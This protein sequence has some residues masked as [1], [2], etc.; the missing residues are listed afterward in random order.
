MKKLVL[1]LSVLGSM[2]VVKAAT[3]QT[4]NSTCHTYYIIDKTNTCRMDNCD[5]N[6][7]IQV[8]D[9]RD[10]RKNTFLGTP[11]SC[12]SCQES[13]DKTSVCLKKN[14]DSLEALISSY[15][16][17]Y[18]GYFGLASNVFGQPPRFPPQNAIFWIRNA[19]F[20]LNMVRALM[21]AYKPD[22]MVQQYS[23]P[24]DLFAVLSELRYNDPGTLI[25]YFL[26][27]LSKDQ[28]DAMRS[29]ALKNESV[30]GGL[31][32]TSY[33]HLFRST[34]ASEFQPNREVL[35]LLKNGMLSKSEVGNSNLR[36]GSLYMKYAYQS[37]NQERQSINQLIQLN[38]SFQAMINRDEFGANLQDAVANAELD[39]ETMRTVQSLLAAK[40]A[41]N[42]QIA[43]ALDGLIGTKTKQIQSK[44][45]EIE[46]NLNSAIA[47]SD[48]RS[49]MNILRG[50]A[51]IRNLDGGLLN[52]TI[53]EGY[54]FLNLKDGPELESIYGDIML[55]L[56]ASMREVKKIVDSLEKLQDGGAFGDFSNEVLAALSDKSVVAKSDAVMEMVIE[57]NSK[58]DQ[59]DDLQRIALSTVIDSYKEIFISFAAKDTD[60]SSQLEVVYNKTQQ[61]IR[62]GMRVPRLGNTYN[63]QLMEP[64]Q[65]TLARIFRP[66]PV[67]PNGV[68]QGT[69][70]HPLSGGY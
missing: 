41:S 31:D 60:L 9:A 23:N 51:A 26:Q 46:R 54:A 50:Y 62:D 64:D 65:A 33:Q 7:K 4:Y 39:T 13:S 35:D 28:R 2:F 48:P 53:R 24:A 29:H 17:M 19:E 16:E 11:I 63:V 1:G 57:L 45:N 69:L 68:I 8:V 47:Q 6:P 21:L 67:G 15:K 14:Q 56:G 5:T 27:K 52:E 58:V 25:P 43:R 18:P 70:P 3:A 49:I 32:S 55:Q 38:G 61:Q 66:L 22:G 40:K 12:V 10:Y 37:V 34:F 20:G 44:L 30:L 59:D 36:Y 42:K